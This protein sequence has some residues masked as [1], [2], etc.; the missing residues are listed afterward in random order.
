M[1]VY[2]CWHCHRHSQPMRPYRDV[3][4]GSVFFLCVNVVDCGQFYRSIHTISKVSA[5]A[6]ELLW[7]S[8]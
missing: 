7:N 5:P 1:A 3:T 6:A 2:T 4:D 8:E